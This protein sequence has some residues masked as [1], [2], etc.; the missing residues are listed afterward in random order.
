MR[1][2]HFQKW[3]R[4]GNSLVLRPSTLQCLVAC[5]VKSEGRRPG[6][7]YNMICGMV[8][9][10]DSRYNSLLTVL[11]TTDR[12]ARQLKHVPERGGSDM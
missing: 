6:E 4:R 7:S 8:D 3:R 10:I 2:L 1:K 12:E 11:S 9:F 5:G